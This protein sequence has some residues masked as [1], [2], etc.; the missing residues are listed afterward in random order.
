MM[1]PRRAAGLSTSET[2]SGCPLAL[3][4]THCL[5]VSILSVL[6]CPVGLTV[7]LEVRLSLSLSIQAAREFMKMFANF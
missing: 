7:I 1:H 3:F 5:R 6:T 2:L 4:G